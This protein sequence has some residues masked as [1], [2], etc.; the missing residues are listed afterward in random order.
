MIVAKLST[1]LATFSIGGIEVNGH[2][3]EVSGA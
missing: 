2:K 3:G 1:E